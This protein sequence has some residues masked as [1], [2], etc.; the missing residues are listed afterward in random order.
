MGEH[1]CFDS[2]DCINKEKEKEVGLDGLKNTLF[3][4]L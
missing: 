2:V 4:Y 1:V 3:E